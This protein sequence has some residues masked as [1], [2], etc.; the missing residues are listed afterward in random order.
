MAG[1]LLLVLPR[2][3]GEPDLC[4]PV[5]ALAA[6]RDEIMDP[7]HHRGSQASSGWLANAAARSCDCDLCDQ[8]VRQV[9]GSLHPQTFGSAAA[10]VHP[11]G[12]GIPAG[13]R[14]GAGDLEG[15]GPRPARRCRRGRGHGGTRRT[16]GTVHRAG[17]T[18]PHDNLDHWLEVAAPVPGWTGFAIGRSIWW[19]GMPAGEPDPEF[20]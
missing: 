14:R 19:D 17:P 3:T 13:L 15:R 4:W 8:S 12:H 9:P 5:A 2:L 10:G 1:L 16:A 6:R 11:E 20:W 18:C 7:M